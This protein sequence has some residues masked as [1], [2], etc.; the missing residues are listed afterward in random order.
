MTRIFMWILEK[1]DDLLQ[2]LW[3]IL[4]RYGDKEE[5]S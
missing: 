4:Y 5:F 2:F 3:R 1:L